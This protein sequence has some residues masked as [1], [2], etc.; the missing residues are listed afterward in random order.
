MR[1]SHDRYVFIEK[2][3]RYEQ[4]DLLRVAVFPD[5]DCGGGAGLPG[6]GGNVGVAG[7]DLLRGVR[8]AFYHFV[9]AT[10]EALTTAKILLRGKAV[11]GVLLHW[12]READRR[13]DLERGHCS[14]KLR[15]ATDATSL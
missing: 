6:I 14:K 15:D 2:S 12:I 11:V 9:G 7:E 10:K 3:P 1:R 5:R 4:S 8:G 13:S